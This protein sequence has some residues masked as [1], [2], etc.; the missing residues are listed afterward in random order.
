MFA[1]AI[2]GQLGNAGELKTNFIY[3]EDRPFEVRL[4]N[5]KGDDFVFDRDLMSQAFWNPGECGIGIIRTR[6]HGDMFYVSIHFSS[7]VISTI[8]YPKREVKTFLDRTFDVVPFGSE[9][10]D[11]DSFINSFYDDKI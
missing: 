3:D 5:V 2:T 6:T 8:G 4:Q 10:M 7:G 1:C 11:M 9:V